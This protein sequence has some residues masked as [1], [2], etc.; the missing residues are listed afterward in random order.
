MKRWPVIRHIRWMV[1]HSRFQ[2]WWFSEGCYLGDVPNEAD[3]DY[4]ER[5]WKGEK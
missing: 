3:M 2:K 4:L 5:I 1:L